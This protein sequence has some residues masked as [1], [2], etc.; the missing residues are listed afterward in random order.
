M[1]R[2]IRRYRPKTRPDL[3]FWPEKVT[4]GLNISWMVVAA[5]DG[6]DATEVHDDWFANFNDADEIAKQLAEEA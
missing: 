3:A 6:C 1:K 5:V 2:V 4:Q